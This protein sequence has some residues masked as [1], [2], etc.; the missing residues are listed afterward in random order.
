MVR[1]ERLELS[2]PKLI[3]GIVEPKSD[4]FIGI[5]KATISWLIYLFTLVKNGAEREI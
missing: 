2:H 1:K 4:L 5:K 3:L